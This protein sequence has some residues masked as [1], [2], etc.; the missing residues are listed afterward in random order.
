M[1][2]MMKMFAQ[3]TPRGGVRRTERLAVSCEVLECRRLLFNR[4][5]ARLRDG[6]CGVFSFRKRASAMD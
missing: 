2:F 4:G 1:T 6:R 3:T 5:A